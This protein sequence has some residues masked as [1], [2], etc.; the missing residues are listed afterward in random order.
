MGLVLP[1]FSEVIGYSD[2][3][4]EITNDLNNLS[5]HM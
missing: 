1:R 4:I 5:P 2:K 3:N